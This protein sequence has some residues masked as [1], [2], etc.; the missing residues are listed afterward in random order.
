VSTNNTSYLQAFGKQ[1]QTQN[2]TKIFTSIDEVFGYLLPSGLL[3][4]ISTTQLL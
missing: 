1:I 2:I 3:K 4:T